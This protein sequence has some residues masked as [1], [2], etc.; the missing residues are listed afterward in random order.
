MKLTSIFLVSFAI[1][2][3]AVPNPVPSGPYCVYNR[4]STA[5]AVPQP[6]PEPVIKKRDWCLYNYCWK[7]TP[8]PVPRALEVRAPEPAPT[9]PAPEPLP[10][11]KRLIVCPVWAGKFC[12]PR[13]LQVRAPEA[14]PGQIQCLI[15]PCPRPTH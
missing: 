2:V 11:T 1:A 6:A 3:A 7:P 13:A 4:C 15:P 10:L 12:S 14:E 9:P 8:T 5:R